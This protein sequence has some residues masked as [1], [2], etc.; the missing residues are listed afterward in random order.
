VIGSGLLVPDGAHTFPRMATAD[1]I[2]SDVH[3]GAV[4]RATE[5]TFLRFLDHVGQ[6]ARS[7][8]LPGDLF[9]FWFEYGT[10]IPGKHFRVL[11]GLARLV[12]AGIP[13]TMIGGNHDAWG[14]RFLREEVGIT[15][16][17]NTVRLELAGKP[18]LVAH[19]DGLGRGDLRYR[20][21][22][23]FLRSRPT[24]AAFRALHPELGLR[25]ARAVSSTEGKAGGQEVAWGRARYLEE[26]AKSQLR[27][28]PS[29]G[30]VVCGHSHVPTVT[31]VSTG[32][33][34]LNPG[35]WINHYTYITVTEDGEPALHR[36]GDAGQPETGQ[37]A[38]S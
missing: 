28:D 31:Q 38:R 8:L 13:V 4:P 24:V 34:Y 23:A 2:A 6:H 19:G 17:A 25:V 35:D 32:Q 10:V 14:G 29:L 33:Y 37:A 16:Y 12:E 36:W 9:D 22:R 3:L 11:G 5:A 1:F 27:S 26:W 18:A 20:M 15:F 30:W 21:L 7:L